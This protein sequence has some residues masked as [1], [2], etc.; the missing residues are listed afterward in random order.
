MGKSEGGSKESRELENR[1]WY[2]F[3]FRF[4]GGLRKMGAAENK[5]LMHHIFEELSKGK[6][7]PFVASMADV[8]TVLITG[9]MSFRDLG[10]RYVYSVSF[11]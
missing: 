6:S 9:G 11:G 4:S 7:E 5:Q 10:Q 1:D 3:G 8:S 2:N